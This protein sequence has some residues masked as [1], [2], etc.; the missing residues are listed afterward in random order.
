VDR[1]VLDG[2]RKNFKIKKHFSGNEIPPT[3]QAVLAA[4]IDALPKTEKRLLQEASVIGYDIPLSLLHEISSVDD[5]QIRGTLNNLQAA[6]FLYTTQLYPDLQFSFKHALTHDVAYAGL[7][8]DRRREIHRRVVQAIETQYAARIGEQVERLADHALRG[9]LPEKAIMYLRQA[10]TKAAD[11]EAYPEA[12]I[13]FEKALEALA[14]LPESIDTLEKAIDIRFDIRNVLQ[15]L[16]DRERIASYLRE[17]GQLADQIGD[18][19]RMGWVQSYL[20]EQFWMLGQYEES[21]Q[22]GEKALAVAKQPSDLPLQVLTNLHLGLAHH[23][24]GDYVKAREY[25]GWNVTRLEGSLAGERFGI[26]VLPSSFARSFIGWGLAESGKFSEAFNIAE[27]ALRIAE[28]AN[29]PFSCGYAHLGLGVVALRQ[30][31]LRRALRSFERALAAGAFADSPVGFAF[32]A[33]HLGYAL[34][35][36]GRANEGLPILEK[37]IHVAES[38]GFVARHSLRLAY[39]SEAYLTL[40]READA[41]KTATRAL[42]LARKHGERANEAYSLRMLGEIDLNRGNLRN[43]RSRLTASLALAKELG[44]RPL[45]ANCHRGL[46]NL[47]DLGKQKS[48]AERHRDIA[49]SLV[50]TMKMRF[51]G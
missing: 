32:V 26:F 42:E 51:W 48:H 39:A 45:E 34:S 47:F 36:V 22:A 33:L 14:Q 2:T 50:H 6:E 46:A 7:R 8:S 9:Q 16:G 24:R 29:H 18:N 13:L 27:D 19:Q 35:L 10:G 40:G 17:A 12:V 38:R 30:G 49:N 31:N 43:A 1:G 44:M 15:P 20:T 25:F 5:E 41:L 37:T 11:R 4:R 21:I 28:D 3:V 23:T